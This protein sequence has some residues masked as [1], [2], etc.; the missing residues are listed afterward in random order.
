MTDWRAT[1]RTAIGELSLQVDLRGDRA[2]LA[3][4]GPNGSGKTTL[5]RIVAGALS[6]DQGEITVGDATLFSSTRGI[7]LPPEARR[8]G[9]VPQGYGLFPHLDA[10]DNVAFGLS[11]GSKAR[12]RA[13]RREVAKRMLDKLGCAALAARRPQQL[14]GGELQRVALA[15]ALVVE[16]SLL[17]LDEPLSALDVGVRRQVRGFLAAELIQLARPAIVVTH[18][19]RDVA[20]LGARVC[21]LEAGR[22][23][24]SGTLE[25][26]RAA[27]ESDFVA[28]FVGG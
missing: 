16:P 26:L 18:D 13:E 22:I 9:Y 17:L 11:T 23:V 27:P 25:E 2:P 5:L 28:E 1:V 6:P 21:V 12:P 4:V 24:Q 19:S 3:V 8:V 7:D 10:L 15:R 20:A 14:S